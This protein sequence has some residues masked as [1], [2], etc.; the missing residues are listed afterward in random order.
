MSSEFSSGRPG[1][2]SPWL[3]VGWPGI[4][5]VASHVIQQL[6]FLYESTHAEVVVADPTF[7]IEDIVVRDGISF[8][9]P[10][11]RLPFRTVISGGDHDLV[12][13]LPER[14]PQL[15]GMALCRRVVTAAL[16]FGIERV[17]T[18]AAITAAID[19][20]ATPKIN[21]CTPCSLTS[22]DMI[23]R[24]ITP[25]PHGSVRGLNGLMLIAAQEAGVPSQ[26]LI[27]EI[28]NW[29]LQLPSPKTS[30]VLMESFGLLLGKKFNLEYMNKQIDVIE[31]YMVEHKQQTLN[32]FSEDHGPYEMAED[33]AAENHLGTIDRN[34]LETLFAAASIDKTKTAVLKAELD[35]LGEFSNFED[36]FLDLFRE[37]S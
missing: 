4:G 12:L 10:L 20:E 17:I 31:A 16:S 35:R 11:P 34:N 29:G 27:G 14:Q 8:P 23:Q 37:C 32:Q 7:E 3:I 6:D 36:R 26:C 15:G 1:L 19:P 9:G 22:A 2:K 25:M 18:F 33:V 21:F 24:G 30:K 13:F 5:G 28:C